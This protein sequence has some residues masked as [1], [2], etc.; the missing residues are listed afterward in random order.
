MDKDKYKNEINAFSDTSDKQAMKVYIEH[1]Q[2]LYEGRDDTHP[3]VHVKLKNLVE[4][5]AQAVA[6]S[7]TPTPGLTPVAPPVAP[8][9][10][11]PVVPPAPSWQI[12]QPDALSTSMSDAFAEW[13]S[14]T[15][16][17]SESEDSEG[18]KE[19]DA[20]EPIQ[21]AMEAALDQGWAAWR[22]AQE[23]SARGASNGSATNFTALLEAPVA[24]L[25]SPLQFMDHADAAS[26]VAEGAPPSPPR[27]MI[28]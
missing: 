26:Y 10:I 6:N 22:K 27:I 15:K 5:A 21:E 19:E 23:E 24:A 13:M 2:M 18:E 8:P 25:P 1:L 20:W 17:E 11:T 16:E 4:I 7:V 14:R 9:V 3:A 12:L 28:R